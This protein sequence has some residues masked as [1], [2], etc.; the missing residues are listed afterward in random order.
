MW[1]GEGGGQG[2]Y[3]HFYQPANFTLGSDAI[4]NTEIHKINIRFA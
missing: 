3:K 2:G 4:L 1:G